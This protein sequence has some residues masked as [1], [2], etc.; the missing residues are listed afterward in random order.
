MVDVARSVAVGMSSC[1]MDS[2]GVALGGS[3]KVTVGTVVRVGV[4]DGRGILVGLAV[5]V[6]ERVAVGDVVLDGR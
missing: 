1:M 2:V 5:N 6:G 4:I 3:V